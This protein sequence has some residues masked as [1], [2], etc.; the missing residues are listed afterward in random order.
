M[1]TKFDIY[2]YIIQK[3][4]KNGTNFMLTRSLV[5]WHVADKT[6]NIYIYYIDIELI[7]IFFYQKLYVKKNKKK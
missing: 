5:Q 4:Q 2:V 3:S 6:N 7:P 1:S